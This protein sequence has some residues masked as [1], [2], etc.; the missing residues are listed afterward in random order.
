MNRSDAFIVAREG[1]AYLAAMFGLLVVF[2]LLDADILPF[3]SFTGFAIIAY[4]Y[5]NPERI[6]PYYQENSIISP[7]DGR[8]VSV[9]TVNACRELEEPCYKI[10]IRS[11]CLDAALLRAPFASE[12]IQTQMR[13]G[14]RLSAASPK[15]GALNEKAVVSFSNQK[16]QSIIVG[17][18]PDH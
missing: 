15:A 9:E 6:V 14:S 16:K 10:V 8:V 17:V 5:R 4:M 3:L 1:W 18:K 13:H 7:V 11:G 2:S 12:V